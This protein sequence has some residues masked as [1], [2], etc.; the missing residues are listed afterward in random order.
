MGIEVALIHP[1]F[2]KGDVRKLNICSPPLGLAYLGAF[3]REQVIT[4]LS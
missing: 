4:S 1:P 2:G 3:L